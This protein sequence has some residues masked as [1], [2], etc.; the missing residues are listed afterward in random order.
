MEA[1]TEEPIIGPDLNAVAEA[2][3]ER[4]LKQVLIMPG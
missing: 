1:Q 4:V 2:N 3:R